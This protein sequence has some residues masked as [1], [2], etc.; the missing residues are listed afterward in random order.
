[1]LRLGGTA[2]LVGGG[3]WHLGGAWVVL[4]WRSADPRRSS[5]GP[6][7]SDEPMRRDGAHAQAGRV[8]SLQASS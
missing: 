5:N 8:Q 4:G 3:R 2:L 1:M 7:G 6:P